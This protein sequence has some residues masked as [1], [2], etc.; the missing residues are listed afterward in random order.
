MRSIIIK[1]LDD[2]FKDVNS[3]DIKKEINILITELV[4]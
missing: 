3:D 2:L 4:I 1:N